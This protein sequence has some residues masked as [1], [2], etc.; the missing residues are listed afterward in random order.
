[1]AFQVLLQPILSAASRASPFMRRGRR[2]PIPPPGIDIRVDL[3]GSFFQ[4][5]RLNARHQRIIMQ[6]LNRTADR[7]RT[8]TRRELA[9]TKGLPQKVLTRRVRAYKA[10]RMRPRA[11]LWIGVKKRITARELGGNI[12][13]TAAGAV[14]IGRRVFKDAFRA[15]MPGGH[16][17]IFTRTP[18]AV[19]KRRPDG[20]YSQLPIEEAV[21]QLMPEAE[22]I[23]RQAAEHHMKRT[24][25]AELK[26]LV[27]RNL[28]LKRI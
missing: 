21:V 14:R 19:H 11:A 15:K 10:S 7:A 17:G 25:P 9:L 6:A 1:M 23:S 28:E 24:F 16:Q 8:D 12:G 18:D 2:Q 5:D 3:K 20:Q 4:L 27:L 13:S 22:R 26:R